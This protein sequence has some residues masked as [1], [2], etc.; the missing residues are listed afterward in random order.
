MTSYPGLFMTIPTA[1]TRHDL[2]TKLVEESG[3]PRDRIVIVSTRSGIRV[4]EGCLV[5]EDLGSVNIHRWW[6]RGID[7]AIRRGATVVA[8]VNDDVTINA[9]SLWAMF[10]CK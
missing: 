8:V 10:T 9:E 3:L 5:V 6:N 1:G 4:P 7:E 2:L